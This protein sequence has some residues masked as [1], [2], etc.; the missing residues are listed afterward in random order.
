ML[1]Q[2]DDIDIATDKIKN[3]YFLCCSLH[4]DLLCWSSAKDQTMFRKNVN[5]D[6][7]LSSSYLHW[8]WSFEMIHFFLALIYSS[9][10][11]ILFCIEHL[12]EFV[13]QLRNK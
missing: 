9:C 2:I 4:E 10:R 8:F 11:K 12:W 13:S 1:T 5:N 3:L 6:L 7:S